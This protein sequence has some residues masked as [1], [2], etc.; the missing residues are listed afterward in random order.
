MARFCT[1]CGTE[2]PDNVAFCTECGTKAPEA[3]TPE[4]QSQQQVTTQEKTPVT[5]AAASNDL[6][7][8]PQTAQQPVYQSPPQQINQTPPQQINQ[9]PLQ[10]QQQPQ[11]QQPPI[12]KTELVAA[13]V[14]GTK[15]EPISAWGFIG[16]LLLMCIP[17]VGL[18]LTIIWAC[19]GCRKVT[20]RSLARASL[21]MMVIAVILGLII[22]LVGGLLVN[23]FANSIDAGAD[24]GGIFGGITGL[25]DSNSDSGSDNEEMGAL[26]E[27]FSALGAITGGEGDVSGLEGLFGAVEDINRDAEAANDGWPKSLRKYP[28]GKSKAVA[29]YRTEISET[30]EQEMLEW[31]DSLKRDGY[32]YSDFYDFGMSE[33]DMLSSGGWWGTNG[34]YYIS[35]SCYDG[36]VTVDHTTELPDLASYFS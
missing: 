13:D 32:E 24:K 20:K 6:P 25:L 26:G 21:I 9:A 33:E 30:S 5:P 11:Y 15:Y 12:Q 7:Q 2:I 27:L 23:S 4:A 17:I 31:I 14:K 1:N 18:I 16:I 10:Q 8:A 35:V 34:T 3:V 36:T 19:G 28:G 29:S 22:A